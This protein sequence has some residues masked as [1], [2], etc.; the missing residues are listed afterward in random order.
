MM[1]YSLSDLRGAY[2]ARSSWWGYF[3][4]HPMAV[5]CLWPV[6]NFMPW[7]RPEMICT[8]S[9]FVGLS[10]LPFFA[11]GDP[12]QV[13]IGGWLA[14]I[15]NI[16]DSMD[17]KLARLK[18]QAN[19][20]GG[21]L[22]TAFDILKHGMMLSALVIGLYAK[23]PCACFLGIGFAMLMTL[24]WNYANENLLGR[25]RFGLPTPEE[26]NG[27]KSKHTS[28]SSGGLKR[29]A[30][31]WTAFCRDKGLL[32]VPCGV[33]LLTIMFIVGP[34][35][36]YVFEGLVIGSVGFAIYSTIYTVSTLK[37]TKWLTQGMPPKQ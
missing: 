32:P 35:V 36:G 14:L 5:V 24:M 8:S 4:L 17:G 29:L 3:I 33:E 10:S 16:L 15:S 13:W 1:P 18:G 12:H 22:D 19:A 6:A 11:S 28:E 9:F 7:V 37:A 20:F 25:T 26:M 34:L 23:H 30:T 31:R 21:Y 27:T 2:K